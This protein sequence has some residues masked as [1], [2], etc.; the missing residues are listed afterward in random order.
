[1]LTSARS[2]GVPDRARLRL[3]LELFRRATRRVEV[4]SQCPSF[5]PRT[6]NTKYDARGILDHVKVTHARSLRWIQNPHRGLLNCPTGA[7][8]SQDNFCLERVTRG[9]KSKPERLRQRVTTQSALS[10]A[11]GLAREPRQESVRN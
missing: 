9:F 6:Q 4:L 3:Q 1:M 10:I 8:G 2:K 7:G 11:Q 5:E